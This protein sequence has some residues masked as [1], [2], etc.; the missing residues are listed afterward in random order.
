MDGNMEGWRKE[1]L[2]K[3]DVTDKL[4]IVVDPNGLLLDEEIISYLKGKNYILIEYLDYAS[5]RYDYELEYRLGILFK[6]EKYILRVTTE[7]MSIPYDLLQDGFY[8][9]LSFSDIF[10]NIDSDILNVMGT[11]DIDSLYR[12]YKNIPNNISRQESL[13][14]ITKYVYKIPYDNVESIADLYKLLL[15]I[16]YAN[17]SLPDI[18][19]TFIADELSKIAAFNSMNI[20]RFLSSFAYFLSVLQEEWE[21]FT[22][23][24]EN[25]QKVNS[26]HPFKD[27]TL[28]SLVD[29]LFLEK[30]LKPVKTK[31]PIL[32]SKT[33]YPGLLIK[34]D[35][36]LI[37]SANYLF[38]S[39][40]NL[41]SKKINKNVWFDI[42]DKYAEL[43][44]LMISNEIFN[45]KFEEKIKD[46]NKLINIR[47]LEWILQNYAFLINMPYLPSPVMVHH[48]PHYFAS[49]KYNKLALIVMDGMNYY[50]WKQIKYLLSIQDNQLLFDEKAVF[51]WIPTITS[52]SRQAIFSGKIPDEFAMSITTT[53]KEKREWQEFW[54]NNGIHPSY[55]QYVKGLGKKKY[56]NLKE[57]NNPKTKI[58]GIVIDIIDKLTHNALLGNKGLSTEIKTW[59]QS[60]YLLNILTELLDDK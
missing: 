28:W 43:S 41:L 16:Q 60:K 15:N 6:R 50:Q 11:K 52:V 21:T 55:V 1:V 29:N 9:E 56:K 30:K 35:D 23:C 3:I 12:T 27:K 37:N 53:N 54:Q 40:N 22:I 38:E 45:D 13:K 34:E 2:K 46:L 33:Y 48:I 51:S 58:L 18:F 19:I 57:F 8:C 24:I 14:F 17:L 7:E 39:I 31:K 5:F 36:N 20:Y 32:Y 47:F 49:K 42:S 4:I 25:N 59:M 26:A 44:L 10:L